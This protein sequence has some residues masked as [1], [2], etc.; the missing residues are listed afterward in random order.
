MGIIVRSLLTALALIIA[1]PS[2]ALSQTTNI[3]DARDIDA[4]EFAR[5]KT[6]EVFENISVTPEVNISGHLLCQDGQFLYFQKIS[7]CIAARQ[8]NPNF[9]DLV[10]GPDRTLAPINEVE[11]IF[12]ARPSEES[13]LSKLSEGQ[14]IDSE[15]IDF[16]WRFF[17]LPTTF[18]AKTYHLDDKQLPRKY[19]LI[20]KEVRTVPVCSGMQMKEKLNVFSVRQATTPQV[21]LIRQLVKNN[22]LILNSP[23]ANLGSLSYSLE[24]SGLANLKNET[25][26]RGDKKFFDLATPFCNPNVT[27]EEVFWLMGIRNGGGFRNFQSEMLQDLSMGVQVQP[28]LKKADWAALQRRP[29]NPE[30]KA[31]DISCEPGDDL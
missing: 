9:D 20:K 27:N 19:R 25:S 6:L 29:F 22:I 26:E 31:F 4:E 3:L 18:E 16:I 1:H 11:E 17:S 7:D 10:C 8:A 14:P 28:L 24:D 21:Y 2:F 23:Y 13:N 15:K 5:T 30:L 12:A